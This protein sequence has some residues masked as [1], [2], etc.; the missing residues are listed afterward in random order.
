MC[1]AL[2]TLVVAAAFFV[3]VTASTWAA[4]PA[5]PN[6]LLIV[7]DDL[8]DW[9]GFL[10]GHPQ[11][12]TPNLDRLAA[13]GVVF[14]NASCASPL[15]AP[16][17]AA[18]FTGR[19]PFRSGAYGNS[20]NVRRVAPDLVLMSDH[21][22][23][24]GYR[25]L[26]TGKLLHQS[27]QDIY[28]E[29]Y[30]PEQ[31]WSPFEQAETT[32][33]AEEL[34]SKATDNPRHVVEME[35]GRKVTLPLN[36]MPS[37]RAPNLPGAES[38]DWGPL[39]VTDAEM[40]DGKIAT[41]AVERLRR[42]WNEPFFL[43]VGFY[44]PHIPLW[45][46][47]AY[48]KPFP[49]DSIVLPPYLKEDLEDLPDVGRSVAIDAVTAGSHASVVKYKQWQA[50]VAAYLACIHFVD[51][52]VGR[53]LDA[54]DAGPHADNTIVVFLGDH[55]WHLGE[56]DHW[57]KL[58]GWERSV[59]VPLVI[60]PARRD[61]LRYAVGRESQQPVTLIDLYPTLLDYAGLPS[62]ASMLDGVSLL[63]LVRNPAN[64]TGRLVISTFN[65]AHYSVRDERW[66]YLRY[67]DG[68]EELYDLQGDPNEWRNLT[69]QPGSAAIKARM[70][71]AIP[72]VPAPAARA[73]PA[74]NPKKKK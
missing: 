25:T 40:G 51:A 8:N 44:R 52:Q 54:L 60:A 48:F 26:G 72:R 50:A 24:H 69:A 34:P 23:R 62:P 57:G 49:A 7:A 59:R 4:I 74:A 29:S 35:G 46:P 12:R 42:T 14:A 27:E 43:G 18:I 6:V 36:R 70:A 13:R 37:D 67:N 64:R 58:T 47:A 73:L 45:A 9:V 1:I 68:S 19:E 28:D 55:G 33:S 39:D 20:D 38:F 10:R 41:W 65:Q 71:A 21:F 56:K 5:K 31:R 30:F 32:Y 22:K 16:S 63:P 11:T 3:S 53:V 2:R 61:A 15:C 17:R 66:R